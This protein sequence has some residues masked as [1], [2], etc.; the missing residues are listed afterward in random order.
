M[1]LRL[2]LL[3]LPITILNSCVKDSPLIIKSPNEVVVNCILQDSTIQT[4]T[5]TYSKPLD[6]GLYYEPV[7][8]ADVKLFKNDTL[9]GNFEKIGSKT[10][11]INHLPKFN[12]D[13]KLTITISGREVISAFTKIPSKPIISFIG[14]TKYNKKFIQREQL[15]NQ[16]VFALNAETDGRWDNPFETPK[17]NSA[18]KLIESIATNHTEADRFNQSGD[19]SDI[20]GDNSTLPAYSFY[21]HL[22]SNTDSIAFDIEAPFYDQCFVVFR[23]SSDEYDKYLKSSLQKMQ[24]YIDENDPVVWFDE[25]EIYSNIENGVGIFG[26]YTDTTFVFGQ[27]KI[28]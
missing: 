3:I 14:E 23:N 26:A 15:N 8:E 27:I 2:L 4:L 1:K 10:W 17:I 25:N 5:L 16:W 9:I 21:V 11:E 13:Y 28:P 24:A 6:K 12:S 19:L 20:I 7:Q 18:D 22:I